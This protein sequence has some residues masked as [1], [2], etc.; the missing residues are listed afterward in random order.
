MPPNKKT[1]FNLGWLEMK[2]YSS[3]IS[4]VENDQ[5]SAYCKLCFKTFT[6]S[7]MGEK[8]LSSHMKSQKHRQ[9]VLSAEQSKSMAL[10]L[11]TKTNATSTITSTTLSENVSVDLDSTNAPK[12]SSIH[13]SN[14]TSVLQQ[15]L[16]AYC[17]SVSLVEEKKGL[18]SMLVRENVSKAEIFG[19]C[20]H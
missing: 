19:V 15:P 13:C 5:L 16:C 8:S 14:C 2:E 4:A 18:S 12:E 20:M 11:S 6:L 3:W 1:R 10:F 7:N 17:A 9:K